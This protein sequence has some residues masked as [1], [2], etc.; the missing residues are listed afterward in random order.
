MTLWFARNIFVHKMRVCDSTLK[1]A[2]EM[3]FLFMVNCHATITL[4]MAKKLTLS[5]RQSR[6]LI[7]R[8]SIVSRFLVETKV[9]EKC[10]AQNMV[11][12]W[13]YPYGHFTGNGERLLKWFYLYRSTLARKN[14]NYYRPQ[15]YLLQMKF[16]IPT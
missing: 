10:T 12:I 5:M 14:S 3:T 6:Y 9:T 8:C 4:V 16:L 2:R 7:F 1:N 15:L 11:I 13:S